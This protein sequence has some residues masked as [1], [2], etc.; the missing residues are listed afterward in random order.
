MSGV[1]V[2]LREVYK[3]YG[4]Q[5]LGTDLY[6]SQG[7]IFS[8]TQTNDYIGF[9]SSQGKGHRALAFFLILYSNMAVRL[10]LEET[11]SIRSDYARSSEQETY[12]Q[13]ISDL[14]AAIPDL[15]KAPVTGRFYKRTAQHL[16]AGVYLTRAIRISDSVNLILIIVILLKAT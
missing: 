12:T 9:D 8:F 2:A 13:I 5:F 16:L 1:Y 3:D 11:T 4:S 10:E 15:Q 7:E 14:A 6:T